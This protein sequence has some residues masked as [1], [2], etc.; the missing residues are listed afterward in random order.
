[1]D[2]K[3]WVVLIILTLLVLPDFLFNYIDVNPDIQLILS[4]IIT[5]GGI[6]IYL[7]IN[8]KMTNQQTNYRNSHNPFT[9]IVL[10][11]LLMLWKTDD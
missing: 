5:F 6:V 9:F 2:K 4:T 1:M 7:Y 11:T 10:I 8:H 3:I